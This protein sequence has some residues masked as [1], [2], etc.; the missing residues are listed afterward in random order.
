MAADLGQRSSGHLGDRRV[1]G[2]GV[3]TFAGAL[4]GGPQL[5][6]RRPRLAVDGTAPPPRP[7]LLGH[8]GEERGE[9]AKQ[10]RQGETQG[11]AGRFGACFVALVGPVLDQLEVVVGERPEPRLGA[12]E[13]P[14][15]VEP[16]EGPG[17]L[18][19]QVGQS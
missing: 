6:G 5:I 2:T 13:C 7:D 4:G 17:G 18:V 14:G 12:L 15:V 10:R 1:H 8:E 16:V 19:D 11:V 9:Q 3:G